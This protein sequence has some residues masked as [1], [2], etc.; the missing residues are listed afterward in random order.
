MRKDW[1]QLVPSHHPGQLY[2]PGRA[3]QI[4]QSRFKARSGNKGLSVMRLKEFSS[5]AATELRLPRV[6]LEILWVVRLSN[7]LNSRIIRSLCEMQ[8]AS[9]A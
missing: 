6:S 3:A 4:L 1:S 2:E 5:H 9:E 8:G 7:P